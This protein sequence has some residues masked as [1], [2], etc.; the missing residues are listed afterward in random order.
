MF[1]FA[2]VHW[3]VVL[4]FRFLFIYFYYYHYVDEY[5]CAPSPPRRE[6]QTKKKNVRRSIVDV[7]CRATARYRSA[8]VAIK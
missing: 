1:R 2:R 8:A 3:R 4:N 7:D 5:I 6:R